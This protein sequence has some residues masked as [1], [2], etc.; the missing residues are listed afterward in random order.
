MPFWLAP[1]GALAIGMALK[2]ARYVTGRH[3]TI[4]LDGSF[5]GAS[6][7]AISIGGQ[8]LFRDGLGPLLPGYEG[9]VRVGAERW[10]ASLEPGAEPLSEDATVRVC[11]VKGHTLIVREQPRARENSL[12]PEKTALSE[13]K[14]P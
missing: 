6:L 4:S 11:E 3:K 7:D 5:H 1:G 10:R 14:Q 13:R 8:G 2:L 12:E 9:W